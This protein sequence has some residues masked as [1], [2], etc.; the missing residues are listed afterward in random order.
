MKSIISYL[1]L[2]GSLYPI[3]SSSLPIPEK[4]YVLSSIQEMVPLTTGIWAGMGAAAGANIG[5]GGAASGYTAGAMVGGG[6]G[7]VGSSVLGQIR[8]WH[9]DPCSSA[10]ESRMS[11]KVKALYGGGLAAILPGR[12]VAAPVAAWT[13]YFVDRAIKNIDHEAGVC[14]RPY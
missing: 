1:C 3:T 13:T 10:E 6:I 5:P 14:E 11:P 9:N 12:V 8:K 4:H 2:L 7:L